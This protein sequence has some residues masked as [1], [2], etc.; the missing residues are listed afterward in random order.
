MHQRGNFIKNA[1]KSMTL[2]QIVTSNFYSISWKH[3]LDHILDCSKYCYLFGLFWI[4]PLH[5]KLNN[6][7]NLEQLKR[8]FLNKIQICTMT[9]IHC[10]VTSLKTNIQHAV[11]LQY[12]GMP[13]S[14][15]LYT[16]KIKWFF[17]LLYL[18]IDTAR[19]NADLS[20]KVT[21]TFRKIYLIYDRSMWMGLPVF[22]WIGIF[23]RWIRDF[24][25]SSN[26][27][28]LFWQ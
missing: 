2:I 25:F 28:Y 18:Y 19:V 22:N 6:R 8:N 27:K 20:S 16:E 14:Y 17:P 26:I 3:S 15:I 7:N 10:V 4:L 5:N 9:H 24:E 23:L 11:S 21:Y 1:K 13:C 12:V